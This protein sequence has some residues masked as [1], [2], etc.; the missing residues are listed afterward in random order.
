MVINKIN[1]IEKE[2]MNPLEF[3]DNRKCLILDSYNAYLLGENKKI[4]FCDIFENSRLAD[5]SYSGCYVLPNELLTIREVYER[6]LVN[7]IKRMLLKKVIELE[8]LDA[9]TSNLVSKYEIYTK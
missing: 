3:L 4:N 9:E 1:L 5:Q 2:L 8:E 6:L 7:E